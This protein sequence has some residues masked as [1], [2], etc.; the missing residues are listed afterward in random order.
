MCKALLAEFNRN[1]SPPEIEASQNM[2][3][4]VNNNDGYESD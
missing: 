3:N 1:A 2:A 4:I